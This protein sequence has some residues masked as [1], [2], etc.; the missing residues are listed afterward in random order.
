LL[1]LFIPI[2]TTRTTITI[3]ATC[4]FYL[5]HFLTDSTTCRHHTTCTCLP[6]HHHLPATTSPP[7]GLHCHQCTSSPAD[8]PAILTCT[9]FYLHFCSTGFSVLP[10]DSAVHLRSACLRRTCRPPLPGGSATCCRLPAV[11]AYGLTPLPA[12]LCL[13]SACAFSPPPQD[14]PFHA[15]VTTSYCLPAAVPHNTATSYLPFV[16]TTL[17]TCRYWN[18]CTTSA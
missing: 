16:P 9:A 7:L 11:T 3:P 18:T 13:R 1:D 4:L 17:R 10:P 8:F 5:L 14:P 15:A 12:C 6:A 2:T